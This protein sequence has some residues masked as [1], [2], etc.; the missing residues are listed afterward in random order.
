MAK[1]K[2]TS[3][4]KAQKNKV[5]GDLRS[6]II[7][8]LSAFESLNLLSTSV[9]TLSR[10]WCRT[11][12]PMK[13]W[14]MGYGVPFG[15]LV[16]Y[17]G[18]ESSG[19]TTTTLETASF[20]QRRFGAIVVAFDA[21]HSLD[22]DMIARTKIRRDSLLTVDEDI[23]SN[24]TL[25][26]DSMRDYADMV[27]DMQSKTKPENRVPVVF[28]WDSVGGTQTKTNSDLTKKGMTATRVGEVAGMLTEGLKNLK[29]II[30]KNDILL[31]VCN[32]VRAN[33]GVMWGETEKSCGGHAFYHFAD[34]RI[35]VRMGTHYKSTKAGSED[36]KGMKPILERAGEAYGTLIELYGKKNK[37]SNPY[38]KCTLVNY[39]SSGINE[40][41]SALLYG[42]YEKGVVTQL[43]KGKLE[44]NGI[45]GTLPTLIKQIEGDKKLKA[46]LLRELRTPDKNGEIHMEPTYLSPPEMVVDSEDLDEDLLEDDYEVTTEAP[47]IKKKK[48]LRPVVEDDDDE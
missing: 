26:L 14:V 29:P 2:I 7:Q 44:W 43:T 25:I 40:V 30:S 22:D 24:M 18:G 28:L 15:S 11:N 41:H 20:L 47:T 45:E 6:K 19:K 27:A 4:Q 46:K 32:Q 3:S 33:I 37:L 1:L 39:F 35:R 48:K 17:Y 23:T 12:L 38:R 5:E 21:E 42:A 8:K 10:L 31:L 9:D 36:G 34:I 13:D 16:E